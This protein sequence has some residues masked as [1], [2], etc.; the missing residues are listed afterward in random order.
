MKVLSIHQKNMINMKTH[1]VVPY[2]EVGSLNI[3]PPFHQAKFTGRIARS[4]GLYGWPTVCW[5]QWTGGRFASTWSLSQPS[6]GVLLEKLRNFNGEFL[7]KPR[8]I[9]GKKATDRSNM[10]VF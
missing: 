5:E 2:T 8:L 3:K 9:S 1:I 7:E 6:H 4:H 10:I